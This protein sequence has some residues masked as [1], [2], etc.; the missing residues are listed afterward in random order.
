[1]FQLQNHVKDDDEENVED[2][3]EEPKV[4]HLDLCRGGE[5]ALHGL[6]EGGEDEQGG[7]G[8]HE[9]LIQVV[10][11]QEE[12]EVGQQPQQERLKKVRDQLVEVKSVKIQNKNKKRF[13]LLV[14]NFPPI[15]NIQQNMQSEQQVQVCTGV[16][17]KINGFRFALIQFGL[18]CLI[19]FGLVWFAY[20]TDTQT[21]K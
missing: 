18:V 7:D 5:S 9:S 11:R 12:S 14:V 8:A 4:D 17:H 3:P 20:S 21:N 13:C 6:E 1:M 10:E 2:V 16:A 15:L 19:E